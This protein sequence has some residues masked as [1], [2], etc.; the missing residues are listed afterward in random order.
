MVIYSTSISYR[1]NPGYEERL[2]WPKPKL[3]PTLRNAKVSLLANNLNL[4]QSFEG[5]KP[6]PMES[7][8]QGEGFGYTLY[9]TKIECD[10]NLIVSDEKLE[11]NG[12]LHSLRGRCHFFAIEGDGNLKSCG[13]PILLSGPESVTVESVQLTLTD[14]SPI[15]FMTENPGRVNFENTQPLDS[16]HKGLLD[17]LNLGKVRFT[18]PEGIIDR[19][20]SMYLISKSAI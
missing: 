12:F 17:K 6:V 7:I 15:V 1:L 9:A 10:E 5:S 8:G 3:Y 11:V 2:I 14:S 19:F 20:L 13:Q 16:E 4:L 18:Q